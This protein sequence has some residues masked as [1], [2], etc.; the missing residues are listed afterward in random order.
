MHE[1]NARI[2]YPCEKNIA[3]QAKTPGIAAGRWVHES[4]SSTVPDW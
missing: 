1:L 3:G 2:W 4:I